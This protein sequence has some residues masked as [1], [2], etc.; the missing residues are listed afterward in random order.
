MAALSAPSAWSGRRVLVT[1][2]TGLV[3][4]WLTKRLLEEDAHVVALVADSDPRSELVRSGDLAR[5]TVV[6][7]AL[8]DYATVER[9]VVGHEV[10]TVFHL[11]AQALVGP[12]ARA[13]MATMETNVR[14]TYHV[15]ELCRLN[16]DVVRRCVVASSD[17]A[18]GDSDVLP[19]TEDMPLSGRNP[20]DVSKSCADL[21]AQSYAR[22]Y[23]LPIVVTRCGNIFGGGDVNWSRVV[24]GT[25]RSLLRGERPVIRSDGTLVRDYTYVLDVVDAYLLAAE[26]GRSGEAFNVSYESPLSVLALVEAITK[27]MDAGHLEPDIRDE[28]KHEIHDQYL[29]AGLARDRLGWEPGFSFDEALDDTIAWYREVLGA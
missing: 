1:G 6:P 7:G 19:Y 28:A 2:A 18:Y 22:T 3:G 4:S 26:R 27:R 5:T 11:G 29:S 8:E 9:A 14:G 25:I 15:L 24:P 13:P 21:L 23:E 20:Y 16:R 17:K 12:A 10:D